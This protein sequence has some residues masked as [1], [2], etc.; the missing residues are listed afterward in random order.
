[1]TAGKP[2]PGQPWFGDDVAGVQSIGARYLCQVAAISALQATDRPVHVIEIGS[3]IGAS[4]LTWAHAIDRFCPQG[5]SV[6][7]IDPWKGYFSQEQLAFDVYRKMHDLAES[8]S[9]YALFLHNAATGP[10][11]IP[12]RHFRGT[13]RDT[14]PY[15]ASASF[16][17]VYVDGAHDHA[18]VSYDLGEARRL[19]RA[20]GFVCGDDLELQLPDCE[21]PIDAKTASYDGV[22]VPGSGQFFHPGVTLAVH[23]AF[24]VVSSY[25]GFWIM[26]RMAE[27]FAEV[28]LTR[29]PTFVPPHLV[30][31]V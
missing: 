17:L 19:V 29:A 18:S 30:G 21:F 8:G 22:T 10:A 5:G 14:L 16:D 13:S 2:V 3:W 7:C 1:M 20:G 4:A 12:I 6:L 28:D 9:A 25:D 15:L 26:R 23:E 27:G 11:R 31:R 24:G